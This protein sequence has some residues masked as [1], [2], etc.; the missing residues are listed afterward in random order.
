MATILIIFRQENTTTINY[1]LSTVHWRKKT[2]PM[3]IQCH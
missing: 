1:Q 2:S 3:D